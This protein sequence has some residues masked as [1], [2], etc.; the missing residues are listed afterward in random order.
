[1][2]EHWGELCASRKLATAWAERLIGITR[3]ALSPDKNVRG[4]FHGT[5][6]CLSALYRAE[7][8]QDLIDLLSREGF[9]PHRRWAV[10]TLAALG[11]HSE[12]IQLAESSRG[13][14]TSNAD[15]DR[16]CE[17]ILLSAGAIDEAYR[18]YG[19]TANRAGTY[20][21]TFRAV[22]RKYPAKNTRAP[23]CTTWCAQHPVTRPNGSPLPRTKASTTR[24][25]RWPTP[26]RAIHGR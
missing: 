26:R 17:E 19:L 6:A 22:V 18:R 16:V 21:G 25:W 12:A 2:A 13:P 3:L 9:W 14:W 11:R 10:K 5:T 7:R 24:R 15:V 4:Y 1:L 8:Y 23:S 20:L